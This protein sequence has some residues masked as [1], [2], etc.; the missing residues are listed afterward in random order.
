MKDVYLSKSD[1]DL[2]SLL[3]NQDNL[4]LETL[5]NR[6]YPALCKFTSIYIK[7]YNKAEELIADLFMK[8]WDRRNELQVKS[9]KKYLFTAAKNLAFNEI[10]RVKLYILSINDREDTLDYPDTYLNPHE[11][12]TSRE[13]Y[14]EIIGLIN[15]LPDRQREVLLMSRIDLLEKNIIAD[16]LGISVRTVETLLY[17]AVKNFRSLT[18]DRSKI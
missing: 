12:L 16:L 10:Q 8:L 17:Q 15:L 2:M 18:A 4:A 11:Q 14:S 3:A 13:S 9:I 7:D 1:E 5:F 6:Y